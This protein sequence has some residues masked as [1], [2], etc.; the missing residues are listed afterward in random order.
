MKK[1]GIYAILLAFMLTSC[2]QDSKHETLV[3][4][5]EDGMLVIQGQRTFML[6][7]Y[8]LPK[9]EAPYQELADA[10]FNLVRTPASQEALDLAQQAGL[11][12]WIS[13]GAIDSQH[14]VQSTSELKE[15]ILQF[16]DH[17]ALLLWETVDE[18][19]WTWNKAEWRVPPEPI[20]ET[21]QIIKSID[22]QHPV[23][24]N[25]APANLVGTLERYN[26][27]TDIV[28]CDIYPVIKPNSPP[29]YGLFPDGYHGSMLNPYISQIALY[30]DKMR[31]VAGPNRPVF[32]VLQAFAWE[33][34]REKPIDSL[35]LYPTHHE[36]RF[37]AYQTIINGAN[38]IN[39]WGLNYVPPRAP[40]WN[41]LKSVVSELASI[42]DILASTP[43]TIRLVK[44]YHE[45]G[46][47]IDMGVQILTKKARGS[48]YL[49]TVNTDKN[50][51][52]VSISGFGRD[53]VAKVLFE[54][55]K[56]Q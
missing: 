52:K 2:R 42:K 46:Y 19:A 48:Y 8:H 3:H 6:G 17:P 4:Y 18:P 1:F 27:G 12:S 31:K 29:L 23:Y 21:Y 43:R 10:G 41:D 49:F 25:H 24:L 14:Q 20:I 26:P 44:R 22:A 47:D 51:A 50:P 15:K 9:S 30:V 40:F 37:M 28:A 45:L 33:N 5:D 13:V 16:K 38:G 11:Y 54:N 53:K 32:M 7:S 39:F 34:L 55:R 36:L 35:V 56:I